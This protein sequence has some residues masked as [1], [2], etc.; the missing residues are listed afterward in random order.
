M[1]SKTR[2]RL[3]QSSLH[4]RATYVVIQF[5][6]NFG[7]IHTPVAPLGNVW[8]AKDLDQSLSV[9]TCSLTMYYDTTYINH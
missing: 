3:A 4:A 7:P 9:L 1:P 5:I 6:T 2:I 8:D